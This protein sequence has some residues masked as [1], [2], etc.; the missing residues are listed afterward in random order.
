MTIKLCDQHQEMEHSVHEETSDNS[1]IR[2]F[3]AGQTI[4]VTGGTG[5]VGKILIEKLLRTCNDLRRIYILV[6][7]KKGKSEIDRFKEIF[8]Q[9]CFG[10]LKK[11]YPNF[12]EK[13]SLVNGDCC[14]PDI[15]LSPESK[16]MLIKEVTSIFHVAAT[17]R[18]D[19]HLRLAAYINV[20]SVRDLL[21]MAKQMPQLKGFLYVSTAYSHCPRDEILERFYRPPIKGDNLLNVVDSLDDET[22]T[23]ITP[24]L[25]GEWPNTYVFTK[26]VAESVIKEESSGLPVVMFRPAIVTVSVEEPMPGWIDNLHGVNGVVA[27]A[28][29]GLLRTMPARPD[30]NAEIVPV[31][32][33]VNGMITAL[34]DTACRKS[35]GEKHEKV[36]VFNFAAS[37][38]MN[39]TYGN[40]IK[41]CEEYVN[42]YPLNKAVWCYCFRLRPGLVS[43]ELA[44]F[45]LHIIPAYI[46]DFLLMCLGRKTIAVAGYR[47]AHKFLDV[48]AYFAQKNWKFGS[49]NMK[50]LLNNMN[51]K[52]QELFPFDLRKVPISKVIRE[53]IIGGRVYLLKDPLDTLPNAK[54]RNFKLKIAHYTLLAILMCFLFKIVFFIFGL[55]F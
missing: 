26:A 40:F 42:I 49:E 39:L 31:D 45:F 18:F 32:F 54:R 1:E 10:R 6:R 12:F 22:L 7:T 23:R 19:Q 55:V 15:G 14:Q 16:N 9:E 4:F 24:K 34:W 52:D 30:V 20:R 25:L 53:G 11:E 50:N 36:T 48:I 37:P 28:G 5:F 51:K 21:K 33:V 17:V 47:K 43:H 46:I 35:K 29:L 27:G 2:K 3:F 41:M 8:D 38:W 44:F 13:V